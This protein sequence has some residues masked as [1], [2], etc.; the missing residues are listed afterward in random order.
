[1][2]LKGVTW[3]LGLL[4]ALFGVGM[5]APAMVAFHYHTGH[6]SHFVL[7]G[8]I[9]A[10]IGLL[11]MRSTGP[12]PQKLSHK[13]GFLIVALAWVILSC[14][15]AVPFWITGTCASVMDGLFESA[16]GMTTTG[17]TILT[18]LDSQPPSILFWRSMQQWLGGMGII[19]LTVAI[20]P[21]LGVGGMQLLRAETPGPI[22]DK[23]TARVTETAK[24]LWSIY[25]GM[26]VICALAFWYAGMSVF[27]AVNH[28]MTTLST[29]GFSTHDASFGYF[30]Q[31]ALRWI[32][33]I[34]MFLAGANFTL[35]FASLRRGLPLAIY[36]RDDEFLAYTKGVLIL[37]VLMALIV[38][39]NH[40]GRIEDIVFNVVSI[41]TTSGFAANDYSL[42][43]QGTGL[44]FLAAMLIGGSAGSTSGG[45]K[46]VRVLLMF[47]QGMREIGRLIHPHALIPV[48]LGKRG[49][50][51]DMMQAIWGFFALFMLCFGVLAVAVAYTGVDMLTAVS[52]A[53]AC[54]SNTGPGFGEV[55]PASNYA[56]LPD[57]A[58]GIL[59]LGMIL[60]RLEIFTLFV[61]IVPRFWRP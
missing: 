7:S 44:L 38:I 16:S 60:G 52:A 57:P 27:D 21:L 39:P 12:A 15:G 1:M 33:I 18:H 53:A 20:I 8:S 42:W 23:L 17:A 22:K 37:V 32:A 51:E 55:G 24:V 30:H 58:K 29:G 43:P 19:V 4:S 46:V 5:A 61:L 11:L 10:L 26:T 35:H 49:L 13:D 3:T 6:V 56:A 31:P 36:L 14:F 59:F 47:R 25:L 45:I 48:R 40:T 41:I 50:S 54:I 34:F 28:A 9:T 2:S